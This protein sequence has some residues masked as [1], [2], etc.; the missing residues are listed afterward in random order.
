MKRIMMFR[1]PENICNDLFGALNE[2]IQQ[3]LIE[4][5][6]EYTVIDCRKPEEQIVR[7]VLEAL[8]KDEYDAA[9]GFN[10]RGMYRLKMENGDNAFDHYGVPFF[11]WIVD[12][13]MDHY[14]GLFSTC[15]DYH[16]ICIDKNHE[17]F[18]KRYFPDV[19]TVHF[20]PLGGLG[21]EKNTIDLDKR[22]YD[23]SLCAGFMKE[24]PKDMLEHIKGF[25]EPMRSLTLLMID[26]MMSDRNLDTEEAFY[27]V[28]EEQ[29]YDIGNMTVEELRNYYRMVHGAHL[30]MRYYVRYEIVK[31]L[32]Q[33]PVHLHLFGDGWR[34]HLGMER[35][36]SRTVFHPSVSFKETSEVFANSKIVLN[37]MPWFKNGTHDR[38][39]SGMLHR[40]AVLTDGN[41]YIEGLPGNILY[42]YDLDKVAELPGMITDILAD[43]Q[44][45]QQT[46]DRGYQ[47]ARK[48]LS[49]KR[50]T[51]QLLE[52]IDK[53]KNG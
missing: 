30:F 51:S 32:A 7:E 34:E 24:T 13:P 20:L 2:L 37:I 33:S 23:I 11:N 38:I 3:E 17:G 10:V 22:D 16:V 50:V 14:E 21:T 45:L 41:R 39:G 1:W 35:Q 8:K 47:Y 52:I 6:I 27:M 29:G 53:V 18:I 19:K 36:Y 49:W 48:N 9:L 4:R 40:A 5:N 15:R 28:M 26:T 31:K 42:L 46:A 43:G 12:P 44:K 25:S